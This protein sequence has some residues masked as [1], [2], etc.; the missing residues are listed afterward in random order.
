MLANGA[1]VRDLD[2]LVQRN[3]GNIS[4]AD[5]QSGRLGSNVL[6]DIVSSVEQAKGNTAF[7][8]S[9]ATPQQIS[10]YLQK[11][12]LTLAQAQRLSGE[13]RGEVDA[14]A[15]NNG[16]SRAS[17]RVTSGTYD[18]SLNSSESAVFGSLS[19]TYGA[20]AARSALDYA[21]Q[22]G[23]APEFAR[24][25]IKMDEQS[26]QDFRQFVTE[27]RS[28]PTLTDDQVKAKVQEFRQ[29]HPNSPLTEQDIIKVIRSQD[30]RKVK[31]DG[32]QAGNFGE[33]HDERRAE[34]REAGIEASV[35]GAHRKTVAEIKAKPSSADAD[36]DVLE[37]GLNEAET[38]QASVIPSTKSG[39]VTMATAESKQRNVASTA[40]DK[41][42]KQPE[43]T[44]STAKSQ[45]PQ[46]L[47]AN[48]KAP[49]L[50][51]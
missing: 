12:G 28:D 8:W 6:G 18:H 40:G 20:T 7:N 13:V 24:K 27:M 42:I 46:K 2:G 22:L 29:K 23:A 19:K 5:I 32:P 9:S 33:N 16:S 4:R 21:T 17:D 43:Q 10:A 49:Q 51:A 38:R 30:Q 41:N 25:F 31:N 11:L 37:A 47:A 48:T 44:A 15:G 14:R 50:T 34:V 36:L 1:A 26:R 35:E 39:P 3:V 45:A